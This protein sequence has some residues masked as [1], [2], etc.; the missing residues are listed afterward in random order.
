M[1]YHHRRNCPL[2]GQSQLLKLSNHLKQ[3]HGIVGTERRNILQ[4]VN[5][6]STNTSS[7]KEKPK[8]NI[9]SAPLSSTMQ[10][11]ERNLDYIKVLCQCNSKQHKALLAAAD[12]DLIKCLCECSANV[13]KGNIPVSSGQ[14]KK[15]TKYKTHLRLLSNKRVS[16]GK[17]KAT[18]VQ[19]GGFLLPLILPA[20]LGAVPALIQQV[21]KLVRRK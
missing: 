16:L 1:P 21:G 6:I 18:L 13:I 7:Q 14:K 20:V 9:S 4:K 8:T 15:L 12:P 19:R 17:K 11:L 5:T 3:T 10:R 2:C